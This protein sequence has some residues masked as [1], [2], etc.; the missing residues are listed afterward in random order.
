MKEQTTQKYKVMWEKFEEQLRYRIERAQNEPID[1]MDW[2]IE[3]AMK[4]LTALAREAV[5]EEDKASV[6]TVKKFGNMK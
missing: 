6:K 5:R 2:F 4:E 1:D 3:C